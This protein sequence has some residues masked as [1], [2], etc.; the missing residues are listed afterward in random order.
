MTQPDAL[1]DALVAIGQW[2]KS[3]GYRFT[4]VTPT[5]HARVNAR[6][7][8]AVAQD[9][10]GVFGWNRPFALNLLPAPVMRQLERGD[11]LEPCKEL[12][13]SR[14]RFS[15]LDEL[16]FAHSAFPTTE[17]DAVFFGPDTYRFCQLVRSELL[18]RPLPAAARIVDAGCGAGPGGI[19]AAMPD[20][21][22]SHQLVL[23][24]INPQ[25]LRFA[26]ANACLAGT[27]NTSFVRSDLFAEVPGL[28]DLIVANPPY[29]VDAA[30]RVYRHGGGPMGTGLGERIV[31]EG[32]PLLAPGGR[33]ML[34]TGVPVVDGSDCFLASLQTLMQTPGYR[35]S[36]REIDPDV[37]GEELDM[38]A[39]AHTDRIA[40]VALLAQRLA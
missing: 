2:L 24:D 29:L 6:R 14:V 13:R 3:C 39:Y 21:E 12:L 16:L 8:A 9:A 32:L 10:R 26:Q 25:A 30:E 23:A 7:A 17:A 35:F 36:Y 1:V 33:L 34:Y 40:A 11:L 22:A 31:A 18:S 38:P 28:F 37:F 27:G 15:T 4:T 19:A 5:T 20:T